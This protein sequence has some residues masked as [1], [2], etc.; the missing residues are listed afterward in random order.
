MQNNYNMPGYTK[1]KNNTYGYI[2]PMS[3]YSNAVPMGLGM[4]TSLGQYFDARG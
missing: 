4:L 3:W 2:E 1:G